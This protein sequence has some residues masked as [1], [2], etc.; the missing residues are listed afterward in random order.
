M[1]KFLVCAAA[2]VAVAT[3]TLAPAANGADQAAKPADPAAAALLSAFMPGVGEWYNRGFVG[4]FPWAECVVG[5]VCC[6]FQISSVI[7]AVNGNTE[8]KMRVDF[9]SAPVA[10]K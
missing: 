3:M 10:A 8:D 2:L 7:D 6:L 4:A 1:K 9:W 5:H